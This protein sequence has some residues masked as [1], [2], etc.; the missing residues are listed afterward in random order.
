MSDK[1][2]SL[3]L[4]IE[5]SGLP[6][7]SPTAPPQAD[8]SAAQ[9]SSQQTIIPVDRIESVV[10]QAASNADALHDPAG[11]ETGIAVI[12]TITA[13][14]GPVQSALAYAETLKGTLDC[15]D[16]CAG[17]VNGVIGLVKDLADVSLHL[18]CCFCYHSAITS[19]PP[20]LEDCRRRSGQSIRSEWQ[21]LE[22]FEVYLSNVVVSARQKPRTT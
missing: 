9:S 8:H 18:F 10:G 11:L 4:N 17:L 7:S 12:D 1:N 20:Y 19:D 3:E 15:L 13:S 22:T 14:V 5:F 21:F 6:S 16:D 2:P